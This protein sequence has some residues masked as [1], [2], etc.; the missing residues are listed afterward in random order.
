MP[1]GKYPAWTAMPKPRWHDP[2]GRPMLFRYEKAFGLGFD[3]R[4]LRQPILYGGD[5]MGMMPT[6]TLL[7]LSDESAE[8]L[9]RYGL[10]WFLPFVEK[11][12]AWQDFSLEELAA[13][14]REAGIEPFTRRG[15]P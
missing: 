13:A 6:S 10:A 15:V 9:A 7:L 11:L 3:P 5:Y 1:E 2:G 8:E 4:S 14:A 12:A